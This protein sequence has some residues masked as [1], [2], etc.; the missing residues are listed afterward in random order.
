MP[1]PEIV[2]DE[3]KHKYTV[4]GEVYPSVTT[5]IGATVPKELSWWGMKIGCHAIYDLLQEPSYREAI[6]GETT[7]Y[8]PSRGH[9]RLIES[10]DDLVELLKTAKRTTNHEMRKGGEKGDLLHKA[11]EY[12]AT[13]GE[14][15]DPMTAP[16]EQRPR[17]FALA[18]WILDTDPEFLANEVRTAS[19]RFRYAG[20]F[21]FR[22]RVGRGPRKGQIGLIDLKTTKYVYPESQFPQLEAYEKA[23]TESGEDPTD[24]RAVLHLPPEGDA[25]LA[26]STDDFNDFLV[27]LKHYQSIQAR[28]DKMRKPRGRKRAA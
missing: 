16:A 10:G 18:R 5:I 1:R 21:D 28:K 3:D 9:Y 17:Y 25:E 2:F 11:L 26:V 13:K 19:T 20:T 6:T 22:A 15:P 23:E 14:V 24:F 7:F 4:N 27:L 12:Y 8:D